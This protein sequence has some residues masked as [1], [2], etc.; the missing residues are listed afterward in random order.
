MIKFA[1]GW[2]PNEKWIQMIQSV[3]MSVAP[4]G[5][6]EVRS[7]LNCFHRILSTIHLYQIY[8]MMCG[9][10]SNENAIKMMFMT[11]MDRLRGGRIDFTQ[12]EIDSTMANKA[13]G[14]PKVQPVP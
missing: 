12:E 3:F 10:C 14:S 9:T 1:A 5:L 11:Y 8:P 4:K 6:Q 13:P 7:D 2:Y